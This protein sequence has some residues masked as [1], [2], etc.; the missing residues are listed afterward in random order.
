LNIKHLFPVGEVNGSHGVYRPGGSA[1]NSG[2]V[3][4]FRA[5]EYISKR[6]AGN[7]LNQNSAKKAAE[8][9]IKEILAWIDKSGISK[10]SWKAVRNEF[11]LRM[12]KAGAHIRSTSVLKDSSEDAWKQWKELKNNGCAFKNIKDLAEAL[13]NLQLCFAHA[14]YLE[15]VQAAVKDG[16]GSRGSALVLDE[17]GTQAHLKL[18]T[19]WKFLPENPEFRNKVLE[20]VVLPDGKVENKWVSRRELPKEDAWFETA[21]AAYRNGEIYK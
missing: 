16:V 13:R 4:G 20:T 6:Y 21:W 1:L 11:Q 14:V 2:Q 18:E 5:A 15:A 10:N 19:N 12:S 17:K 3:S 7:T 9:K 8:K